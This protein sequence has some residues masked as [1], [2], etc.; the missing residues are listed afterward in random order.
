MHFTIGFT[1][2]S[3][4]CFFILDNQALYHFP[5]LLVKVNAHC[6]LYYMHI[7]FT[8]CAAFFALL[9]ADR[10]LYLELNAL[11][12]RLAVLTTYPPATS[13][14]Q[15]KYHKSIIVVVMLHSA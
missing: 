15:Y 11:R 2:H 6:I 12:S 10:I 3:V 5:V 4:Y 13:F 14:F 8:L 7:I 9:T 1:L